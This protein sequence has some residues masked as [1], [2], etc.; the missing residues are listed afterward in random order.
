M[1]PDLTWAEAAD[2]V[3]FSRKRLGFTPD[4]MQ[5]RVLSRSVHRG[6]LN[7]TRQWGKSTVTS[8]KALHRALVE[9]KCLVL[10][11]S[12]SRRQSTEF[13]TKTRHFARTLGLKVRGDGANEVSLLLPNGSRLIGLP[14]KESTVRGF[15]N[16]ALL[17]IDEASRVPDSLF[18]ALTPM[19][20]TGNGDL[21][22]MS[23]PAGAR[24]FFWETW[25]GGGSQW[26]RIA[27][28][29]TE[30]PRISKEFLEEERQRKGDRVFQQ[31]DLCQFVQAED[32]FFND[33]DVQACVRPEI[34]VLWR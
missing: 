33:E 29:A 15:S 17:L 34:P 10:V 13:L 16:P 1:K 2:A 11:A 7:C 9:P 28:P 23:T 20:A 30:C 24:G 32:T 3:L 6:I 26:A 4:P 27:V 12:P 31:E 22:L 8:V 19:L 14:G 21:W 5:E 25:E 18:E